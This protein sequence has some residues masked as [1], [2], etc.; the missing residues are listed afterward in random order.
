MAYNNS[1]N[2]GLCYFFLL[3][4]LFGSRRIVIS[5]EVEQRAEYV[6]QLL[7]RST[8]RRI[9]RQTVPPPTD[10]LSFSQCLY[11]F[12]NIPVLQRL[13]ALSVLSSR[14]YMELVDAR[15]SVGLR[16]GT[17]H[18]NFVLRLH[19]SANYRLPKSCP[20][21]CLVLAGLLRGQCIVQQPLTS[22]ASVAVL[23]R[24]LPCL[25]QCVV[26]LLPRVHNNFV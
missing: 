10:L 8:L 24:S 22:S 18:S 5:S 1:W 9:D 25:I 26:Y 12:L 6:S 2:N 14:P 15:R 11:R 7:L 4:F 16:L 21:P 20:G 23:G 3:I 19:Q 17:Y 13:S